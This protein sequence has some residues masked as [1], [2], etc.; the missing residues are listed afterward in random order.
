[1]DTKKIMT[2]IKEHVTY[3]ATKN[4]LVEACNHMT[5]I[6]IKDR[7]WFMDKLP[8]GEYKSPEEVL[9]ELDIE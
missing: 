2:H 6:P 9:D 4:T 5:D 1:M 8:D 3:P 7:K